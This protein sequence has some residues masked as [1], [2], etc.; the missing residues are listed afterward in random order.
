MNLG[1]MSKEESLEVIQA[2][3]ES[4]SGLQ[5]MKHS[6]KMEFEKVRFADEKTL[7]RQKSHNAEGLVSH[8]K[9]CEIESQLHKNKM[10]KG[11]RR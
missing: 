6:Q 5:A 4:I 7:D 10:I 8:K 3:Y 1:N 9:N 11:I 2:Y